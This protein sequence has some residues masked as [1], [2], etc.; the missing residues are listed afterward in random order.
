MEQ[1][2][3]HSAHDSSLNYVAPAT[4][5]QEKHLSSEA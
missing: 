2:Q 5:P 4:H 1:G 3:L